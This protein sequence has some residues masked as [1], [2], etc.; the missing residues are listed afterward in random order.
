L[1]ASQQVEQMLGRFFDVEFFALAI[2]CDPAPGQVERGR[3]PVDG[4]GLDHDLE[5]ALRRNILLDQRLFGM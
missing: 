5:R 3:W 2:R 4:R 1:S